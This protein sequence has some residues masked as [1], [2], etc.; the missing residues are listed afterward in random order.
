LLNHTK[1]DI[2]A[3]AMSIFGQPYTAL[4]LAAEHAD[5]DTAISLINVLLTHGACGD[6]FLLKILI[7]RKLQED[8][9]QTLLQTLPEHALLSGKIV[10]FAVMHQHFLAVTLLLVR[11]PQALFQRMS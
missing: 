3:E 4:H 10:L 2:N 1:M 11:F 6:V 8:L 7:R 9:L 5:P